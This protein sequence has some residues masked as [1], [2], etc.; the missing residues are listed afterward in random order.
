MPISQ[1]V[2][3][4]HDLPIE[5]DEEGQPGGLPIAEQL[6]KEL[7]SAGWD[8]DEPDNWRDCGWSL[9]CRRAG[10]VLEIAMSGVEGG[11]WMLQVAMDDRPGFIRRAF[12]AKD[13][14]GPDEILALARAVHD[15]FSADSRYA[16]LRWQWD[17]MPGD[18]SPRE[19]AAI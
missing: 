8:V 19:P 16:D 13:S 14:A 7:K 12:G 15:I 4:R 3:F 11:A 6:R 5:R 9:R 17:D 18:A 10:A 1:N 2:L